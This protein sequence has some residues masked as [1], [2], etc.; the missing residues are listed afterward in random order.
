VSVCAGT[1]LACSHLLEPIELERPF[2][3]GVEAFGTRR[4]VFLL[5]SAASARG[6]GRYSFLGR[7]PFAVFEATEAP[8]APP[9]QAAIQVISW[10]E[11]DGSARR[12]A[13][14]SRHIGDPFDA[15]RSLLARFAVDRA[16]LQAS[17]I[18]F[19]AGAVG[20]FG[21]DVGR[22]IEELPAHAIDDIGHPLI[23]FALF[24]VVVAYDHETSATWISAVGRGPTDAIARRRAARQRD[25]CIRELVALPA[26]RRPIA[27]LRC[28]SLAAARSVPVRAHFDATAYGTAV[29]RCKRHIE[30]GDAY[31][32]CLTHR[33]EAMR[34]PEPLQLYGALRAVSPAPFSSYIRFSGGEVVCSSPER[35]LRLGPD[36]IAETRPIKGTR[37]RGANASEDRRLAEELRT[38]AKDRAENVMIVDLVRN[39]LGRVCEYGSIHVAELMAVERYATVFQLVSTVRGRLRPERDALD[40]VRAAFPGGSMTGA[41]KVEA[42]KIIDRIEPVRRGIYSGAIGYLDFTGPM[43]LNIVIRTLVC[44][45]ERVFMNVGGAIVADSDPVEEYEETMH[46]ALA[47]KLALAGACAG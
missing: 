36:R 4:E 21:Y 34:R 11:P 30:C 47:L 1:A 8:D 18:P 35:F 25:A 29:E 9:G 26:K 37:P 6:L 40:L 24:D 38:S 41:P 14:R 33:L 28:S 32:I 31:E 10:R 13:T 46:K 17:E 43:D 44:T 3:A 7:D 5:D 22:V 12:F 45:R 42:M 39:D 20:Y 16:E 27:A 23:R 2:W 15:L 19:L